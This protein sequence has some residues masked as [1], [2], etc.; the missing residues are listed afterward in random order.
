MVKD[1]KKITAAD[2]ATCLSS[3]NIGYLRTITSAKLVENAP[4][5]KSKVERVIFNH[6]K[7]TTTVFWIDGSI[8]TVRC[9]EED[10]FDEEKGL[11]M[12]FVK[13]SFDNR[14]CYNKIM[15]ESL[16]RTPITTLKELRQN[17]LFFT[18]KG[19]FN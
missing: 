3:K 8:T 10:E 19:V 13:R 9:C 14:G 1:I 6:K 11:A 5:P 2:I 16:S 17:S 15:R 4:R 7:K 18:L 12:C